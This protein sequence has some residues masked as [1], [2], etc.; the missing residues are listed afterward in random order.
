MSGSTSV[1]SIEFTAVGFVAPAQSAIVAGM[2]TD[3]NAGFGGNLNPA[4]NTP[5]GQIISSTSAILGNANDQ[6]CSLV[7][8]MDPALATGL[9]QDAIGY[10]YFIQR[11]P[12]EPTEIVVAC[13]G[14]PGVVIPVNA[15]VQDSSGNLYFNTN[16]VVIAGNGTVNAQFEATVTGPIAVPASVTLYTIVPGWNTVTVVSGAVGN[17]IEGTTQFELRRQ[18]SVAVNAQST[19]STIYANVLAVP[20]VLAAFV[21][22]NPLSTSVTIQ[23][24]TIPPNSLFV[25]TAGGNPNDIA[26]AIYN[27]KPVGCGYFSG[28]QTI[29]VQDPNP[30]YEGAGPFTPVSFETAIGAAICFNVTLYS[31]STN[32]QVPSNVQALVAAAIQAG[33]T[34]TDGFNNGGFNPAPSAAGIGSVI[35]AKT[36]YVLDVSNL[37][38]WAKVIDIEIGCS[39][40]PGAT[41][42]GSISGTTLTVSGG[43][44]GTIVVGQFVYGATV[45]PG[46]IITSGAGSSWVV[47]LSQTATSTTISTVAAS[48]TGIQTQINWIPTLQNA[49]VNVILTSTVET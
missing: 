39:L 36:P 46:T 16:Q 15:Y 18:A 40:Y 28:N 21:I 38:A 29:N 10:I 22:D 7:N 31:P 5:Q 25:C 14:E 44:T 3:W 27:K 9:M 17:L 1:P 43:V 37:G 45:A 30:I 34:G 20:D 33:F 12:A 32:T 26:L 13:G 42:T 8:Q 48:Q 19:I 4:L 23:G 41:F 6:F 2:F 24:V 47:G 49:D 35:I 11:L